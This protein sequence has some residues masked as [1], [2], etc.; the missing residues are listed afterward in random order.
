MLYKVCSNMVPVLE[1]RK[2]SSM[3]FELQRHVGVNDISV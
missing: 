2:M 3:E 1:L